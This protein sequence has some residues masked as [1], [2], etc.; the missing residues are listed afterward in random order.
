MK[1]SPDLRPVWRE[2]ISSG[3]GRETGPYAIHPLVVLALSAVRDLALFVRES[4][5]AS[6]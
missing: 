4:V 5:Q 1:T 6:C 3:Y 2:N